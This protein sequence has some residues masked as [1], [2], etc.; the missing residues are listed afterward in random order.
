M[1]KHYV[2]FLSPG[3][4]ISEETT[5]EIDSWDTKKTIKMSKEIKERHGATPYGF[6]FTTRTRKPIEFDSQE[7]DRS[8]MHYLGGTVLTLA[9]IKERNDPKDRILISNM[10]GN[11]YDRVIENTNSWKVTVPFENG[12][13][14]HEIT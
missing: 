3:T 11:G 5:K 7:T 14:V 6:Y 9:E 8:K 4:L 13:I 2:T 10:E 12:D 1:K